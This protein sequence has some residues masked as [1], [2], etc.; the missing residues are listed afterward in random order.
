MAGKMFGENPA[1]DVGG[2]ASGE[3]D[4]D[5][6]RLAL[7]ERRFFGGECVKRCCREDE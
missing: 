6:K 7:I 5:V 3:V 4:D 2:A 1:F